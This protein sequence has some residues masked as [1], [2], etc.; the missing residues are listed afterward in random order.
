MSWIAWSVSI[1]MGNFNPEAKPYVRK[2]VAS[3]NHNAFNRV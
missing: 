2:V 3:L 1:G